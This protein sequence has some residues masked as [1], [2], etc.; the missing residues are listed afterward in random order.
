MIDPSSS[1]EDE[2]SYG[3]MCTN[4]KPGHS[5]L[6][7]YTPS[8]Y[9]RGQLSRMDSYT[10]VNDKYARAQTFLNRPSG[11]AP[12][13]RSM[14]IDPADPN[15]GCKYSSRT[16][17]NKFYDH[18]P[19]EQHEDYDPALQT[20]PA[21]YTS[22]PNSIRQ[23]SYYDNNN[24]S[25][26]ASQEYSN[27]S[28]S[29]MSLNNRETVPYN[30]LGPFSANSQPYSST[31]MQPSG[32]H[33]SSS[34]FVENAP[35]YS[36]S[37]IN[38]VSSAARR[39]SP[40]QSI[41]SAGRQLSID[42]PSQSTSTAVHD[43]AALEQEK[44]EKEEE[45]RRNKLQIYVFVARCIAYPFYSKPPTDLVRRYL[46]VTKQQLKQLQDRFRAFLAGELADVV[47]DGA[48]TNAIQS[49]FEV[50][51]RSDRVASMVK[52]GG[53][54]MHDF[55]EVFRINIEA[56]I[57]ALPEIE[58]LDKTHIS[59][60]WMVKFDQICRG[61]CGPSPAM[62]K[63]QQ[64]QPELVMNK[65]QMYDLYQSILGVKRYEHQV[66][67]NSLTLDNGD[68][69][70][71]QVR[72]ELDGQLQRVDELSATRRLPKLVVKDME[73]LYVDEL[74]KMVNELM[75]RLEAVPVTRGGTSSSFQSKFKKINKSAGSSASLYRSETSEDSSEL[76]LNRL[77]IQLSFSIEIVVVQVKNLKCVPS[78]K[79][80]YCT[81]EVEGAEKLQTGMASASKPHWGTQGDFTINH[82]LPSVK[83]KLFAEASGLLTLDTGKELGRVVI[84]PMCVTS[85]N[86]EW[87]KLILAKNV[88]DDLRIQIS[89]RVEKPSNLKYCG[90]CYALGRNA[91]KKWKRRYICLIQVSTCVARTISRLNQICSLH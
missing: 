22:S 35:K 42:A 20:N 71:A 74:R 66:L 45:L 89:I 51:L 55:R 24:Q 59:S 56:R 18:P 81:M 10:A 12:Y 70:A 17:G 53:C 47:G 60:A 1:E 40:A 5:P 72:R 26:N 15:F 41:S 90:Y 29:T 86:P 85:R 87:Y 2:H 13:N 57:K 75:L 82:P 54:S 9:G 80:V 38:S 16:S 32:Y 34:G 30:H 6:I 28:V 52:A 4:G 14:T 65:E 49:Y 44:A 77:D 63:L 67:F 3:G 64:P 58:G 69:Q 39:N 19:D 33:S 76:N 46:R 37:S 62:Q 50:F 48:F 31:S 61:G 91:F 8:T 11:H 23:P 83:V 21:P 84:N 43:P 78:N 79:M 88:T 68:E 36:T 25:S 73:T 27:L 7:N